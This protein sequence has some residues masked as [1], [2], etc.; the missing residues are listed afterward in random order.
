MRQADW[1]DSHGDLKILISGDFPGG[2][3]VK[4]SP[5]QCKGPGLA[6]WLGN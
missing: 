5:L 4:N 3:V 6:P 2:L 1:W